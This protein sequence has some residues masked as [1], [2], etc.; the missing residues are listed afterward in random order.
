MLD[1]CVFHSLAAHVAQCDYENKEELVAT[2]HDAW[3]CL[4]PRMLNR[5]WASKCVPMRRLV[6]N[7][8]VEIDSPHVGLGAAHLED[9]Q[10]E[11]WRF[12]ERYYA[13][14]HAPKS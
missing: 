10:A 1:M 4:D 11:L 3:Q 9:G 13:V 5:Q 8:D 7:K 6:N 12:I 2:V 14:A